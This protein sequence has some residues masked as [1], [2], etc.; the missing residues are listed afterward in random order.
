VAA[1]RLLRAQGL[2]VRLLLLGEFE[3]GD[4]VDTGTAEF[5]RTDPHVHWLGYVPDPESYYPLMDVFVFPTHREG[6]GRVLLEAAAAGKP[7][8]S[9]RTTGVVDVVL[10]G[11]TG[12]LVPPADAEALARATHTLLADRE[13]AARLGRQARHMVDEH[14]DN[15]IYLHRLA[16]VLDSAT[17]PARNAPLAI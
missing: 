13:L 17:G 1:F 15:A 10:D 5:I 7:V 4:P 9:T 12:L 14:F 2:D 3:H 8:V 16:A 6:L 11:V